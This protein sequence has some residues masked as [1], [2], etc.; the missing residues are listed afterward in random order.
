VVEEIIDLVTGQCLPYHDDEYIRQAAE[1][2]LL[3][4]RGWP[5][6]RIG[7]E[8]RRNL[9]ACGQRMEVRAELALT[10]TQG[11]YGLI[12]R[13]VRGSMVSRERETLAAARLLAEPV[14]PLAMVFNGDD[15]TL[16]E[17][18]SGKVLASGLEAVPAPERLEEL[19]QGIAPLRLNAQEM[20]QAVKVYQAYAFIQCPGVCRA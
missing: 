18:K 13:C 7:V 1:R 14:V 12:M 15:A 2:L 6:E 10:L 4:E 19:C 5:K 8:P 11:G 16:M 20:D 9:S 3:E 17:S